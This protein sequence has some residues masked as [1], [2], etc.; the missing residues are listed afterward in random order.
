METLIDQQW[1]RLANAG[2]WFSG[3]DRVAIANIVRQS[4][5]GQQITTTGVPAI[6]IEAATKVAINAHTIDQAWI[7][8]CQDKGLGSLPMVELTALVSQLS[9]IDTYTVGI[10][11]PLRELPDPVPGE[12]SKEKVK[13]A[14]IMRGW[15]PTRGIAGAPNCFS[16]V[17]AEH[18]ALHDIHTVMYL[19][20]EEMADQ[21]IVNIL[22][23]SQIE[24]LAA[25]TSH[26]NDCF[27]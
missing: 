14:R 1:H 11:N 15:L 17:A 7:E 23:R 4:Q 24:L 20:M 19:S 26:Y 16:A 27:Y 22:H 2:T 12:P 6:I 13:G 25:R 8:H 9:A 21:D 3:K 5:A 10:G 18:Q